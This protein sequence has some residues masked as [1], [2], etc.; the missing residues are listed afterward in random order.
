MAFPNV[1][2]GPDGTQYEQPANAVAKPAGLGRLDGGRPG[3]LPLGTQLILQDGR[4]FRFFENGAATAV[5]GQVWGSAAI[6]STD[7]AC[8][9]AAGAV[10]DRLI[11]FTHGAATVV[12][13][14]F[15]E[16][17]ASLAV[18][19]GL[20]D[21]FKINNHLALQNATAGDVVNFDV[22]SALRHAI[23]TASLTT[24][25]ANPYSACVVVAA[26]IAQTPVGIP[27]VT[28]AASKF[29]WLQTAGPCAVICTGTMTI[30]SPAVMLLTGGTAGTPAPAT[31]ATQPVVGRVLEVETTGRASLLML[32]LDN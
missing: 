28:T 13:N 14:F 29:G 16:G 30:G 18:T 24:L 26:T 6:L 2:F 7:Q 19:P 27:C 3:K 25:T 32:T 12:Q 15:A 17:Y 23:T 20:G 8:T 21:T 11:T 22:G 1:L 4:K 31:A 9:P 10:G 5:V